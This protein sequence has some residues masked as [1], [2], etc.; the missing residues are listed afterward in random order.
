MP[1][2][3][4]LDQITA[5][6]TDAQREAVCYGEGPLLVLAGAGSGKTRVITRRIAYLLG[7]GVAPDRIIAVTFTNKAAD[8]MRRRVEALVGKDVYVSTFH[9]FCARL[10][11]RE[12]GRLGRDASF[13]IYDR[14]DSL[15]VVRRVVREMELDPATYSPRA[16]L[17]FIGLRKD[18]V[19][20][21]R[22][23]RQRALGIEEQTWADVY[24]RYEEQLASNNALDFDDLLLRTLEVFRESPGALQ[25]YQD[26]YLHVLVDEYQDTNLPQHLI[27]RALQGKHRNIT[28][29]GDPDQTIYTWRGARLENLMEFEQDF[30]GAHVVTLK[31][32]YRSSANILRAASACISHNVFRRPKE[33]HTERDEGEPIVVAQFAD[34]F[35]EGR[36]VAE[37]VQE[38]MQDRV[39]PR[40]IAVF[41]RTKNQSLP[42][43][44]AFASL[45]LPH[46]VVDSVGF[47]ER[48]QVKDLRSYLQLLINPRDDV[49]CLRVINTP[50]RG[51]G[52]RT[53]EK[54]QAAAVQRGTSLLEA[55]RDAEQIEALGPRAARAARGFY[56]LHARLSALRARSA[57]KLLS[58]AI[59]LTGYLE[60]QPADEREDAE[61]LLD[62]FMDYAGQYDKRSPEGGLMGFLE[63][64]ALVSDV[65]GWNDQAGAV[66]F[67]TLHSAKGLEFDAVFIVG[68]ERGMLPHQRAMQ[69]HVHDTDRA[70]L[71]E[72][73]RLFYVGMTRARHRLFISH[74]RKRTLRGRQ[75]QAEPSPFLEELPAEGVE[76]LGASGR[77]AASFGR[78][79][80]YVLKQKK[81]SLRIL[82]GGANRLAAGARVS[83]PVYGEGTILETMRMGSRH[84]VRVDFAAHG[85]MVLVLAAADVGRA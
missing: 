83:H 21:P 38:L 2:R 56:E 4:R 77:A 34:S 7:C 39:A 44:D 49:A 35:A 82:D 46:Q 24:Q 31:R 26:A 32:N 57:K 18:R 37:M 11:R 40:E 51:I 5:D 60:R 76:R 47:F 71:E 68:V 75:E 29:V 72:E 30:P 17:D 81:L 62:M 48:R 16:L 9:S 80:D 52:A 53:V 12:I 45:D 79:M 22:E 25:H 59:E 33:L 14:A 61:E 15:R 13:T 58:R 84:V 41:Y 36:W 85:P 6:L 8:E 1:K 55:M 19:E 70:A 66:P 65:D 28:A 63:Q 78:E 73:R 67:M 20:G 42:L 3:S 43:E 27:A 23:C 64:S 50:P 74:A 10:L 69:E 54:L